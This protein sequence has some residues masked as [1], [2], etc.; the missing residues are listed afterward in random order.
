MSGAPDAYRPTLGLRKQVRFTPYDFATNTSRSPATGR[1][2]S[3]NALDPF[4]ERLRAQWPDRKVPA[5]DPKDGGSAAR[6]LFLLEA[7]GPRAVESDLI[8]RHNPDQT[9]RAFNELLAEASI[10]PAETLLWNVVPWYI[11]NTEL[12]KIRP[13]R[14]A[15][16]KQ[17]A[18]HLAEL[19]SLL[20]ALSAVVLVG[21]KARHKSVRDLI[22]REAGHRIK[23]FECYHPSPLVLNGRP[24]NRQKILDELMAV[25]RALDNHDHRRSFG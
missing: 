2:S 25:R 19:L 6:V 17:A 13:A 16:L 3:V 1:K 8:S 12:T 22:E 14:V 15:D 7:P 18:S 21:R 10:T 5:F 20:R 11:G 9:A 24:H 4:V 23:V